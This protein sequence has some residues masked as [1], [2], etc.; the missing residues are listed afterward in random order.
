MEIGLT[1]Q[2]DKCEIIPTAG[3]DNTIPASVFHGF[4]VNTSRNFKLLGAPFGSAEYCEKHTRKRK[5]KAVALLE[6]ISSLQDT[7]CALHLVRQCASFCK[8]AYSVRVVPPALHANSLREFSTDLRNAMQL[9]ISTRI[10]DDGWTQAQLGI[11]AGGLGLRGAHDHA[12]AAFLSSTMACRDLCTAIDQNFDYSDAANDL[13]L[14]ETRATFSAQV[15]PD[16][17]LDLEGSNRSQKSLSRLVDARIEQ[18][19]INAGNLAYK[20]HL[21]LQSLPGAGAWLIAPPSEE[22]L[23]LDP[24]LCKIALQRRLR[25]Q[26]QSADTFCPMCG[27]TMDSF[28]DH[29]VTCSCKG[30]RTVRHNAVRNVTHICA[31]E[32]NM[33]PEREKANLLPAR[34][35]DDV[36]DVE[37]SNGLSDRRRRRPADIYL[38]RGITGSPMA[39]DFAATSGMQ[40]RLLRQSADDSSSAIVAYEQR[41][42]DFIPEGETE[43]TETLCNRQ[44]FCFNPMVLDAHGGGMGKDFRSVVDAIGKQ[45]AAV[46]GLRSDFHSLLIAQRISMTLHRE[47][48]RAI[49][50]RRVDGIGHQQPQASERPT[51]VPMD[52]WQ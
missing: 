10:D 40:S 30:D 36:W 16:A 21:G 49:L 23:K 26:V 50:R 14:A 17:V 5:A 4:N 28:G 1:M 38:P 18:N 3:T 45:A 46:S 42:R 7:Q 19:L 22:I 12:A 44:G 31:Q 15:L 37:A 29:A 13:R 2:R 34:P 39:L 8:L 20:A 33:C 48:A 52:I 6:K 41:K 24:A 9:M 32:A 43:S 27:S 51:V 47:N 35:P 25:Q 11:K